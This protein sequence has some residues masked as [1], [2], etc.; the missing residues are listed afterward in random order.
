MRGFERVEDTRGGF[1][2]VQEWHWNY[3]EAHNP[4]GRGAHAST[5]EGDGADFLRAARGAA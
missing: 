4:R 2:V 1:A 3:R 5:L